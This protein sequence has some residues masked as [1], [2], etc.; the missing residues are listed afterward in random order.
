M[1]TS[2]LETAF[3]DEIAESSDNSSFDPATRLR[4]LNRAYRHVCRNSWVTYRGV[5]TFSITAGDES[6]DLADKLSLS[7][8]DVLDVVKV[9]YLVSGLSN[10]TL[11]KASIGEI[12]TLRNILSDP[13]YYPE[14]Y[15]FWRKD[16]SGVKTAYL[17]IYPPAQ[18]SGTN[19]LLLDWLEKPPDLA[20]DQDPITPFYADDCIVLWA[21][22]YALESLGDARF[23]A[24]YQRALLELRSVRA[25]SHKDAHG[26]INFK[27][28]VLQ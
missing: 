3:L 26:N 6:F 12:K 2:D 19:I 23:P 15:A 4:I 22:A 21:S 27:I 9:L 17:D 8:S 24:K 18:D 11:N 14:R 20:S 28:G 5:S 25:Q 16:V 7:D 10:H 13:S 1:T